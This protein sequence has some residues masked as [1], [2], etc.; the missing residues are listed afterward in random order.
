MSAYYYISTKTFK[1]RNFSQWISRHYELTEFRRRLDWPISVWWF[2]KQYYYYLLNWNVVWIVLCVRS[3][4][5]EINIKVFQSILNFT[6]TAFRKTRDYPCLKH[7]ACAVAR[8]PLSG[9]HIGIS[10]SM[11]VLRITFIHVSW[12]RRRLHIVLLSGSMAT[13]TDVWEWIVKGY[14]NLNHHD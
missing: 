14:Q 5:F 3:F 4:A 11:F 9:P 8:S 13:L 2:Y 10:H 1:K 6:V 12:Q 7:I